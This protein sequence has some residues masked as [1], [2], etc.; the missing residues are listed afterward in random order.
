MESGKSYI[1][2]PRHFLKKINTLGCIPDNAILVTADA[3]GLYPS[4][5]HQAGLNA[6]KEAL[7]K[8]R[9]KRIPTDDLSRWQNLCYVT[10]FLKLI[11]THSNKFQGRL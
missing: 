9:L 10:T 2:D 11:V 5:S 1:I 6:L 7:D 4:I 8:R 3:V